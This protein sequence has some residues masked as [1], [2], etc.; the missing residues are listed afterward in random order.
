[1]GTWTSEI[2]S[3]R[4]VAAFRAMPYVPIYSPK[5]NALLVALRPSQTISTEALYALV[6]LTARYV[7]RE[8]KARLALLTQARAKAGL[9]AS[10]SEFCRE[11]GWPRA[12]FHLRLILATKMVVDGLNRDVSEIRLSAGP[13]VENTT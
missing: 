11:M 12:T 4:L 1:M 7:P 6:G 10:V 9:G 5:R 13:Y 3:E 8:S 2:L